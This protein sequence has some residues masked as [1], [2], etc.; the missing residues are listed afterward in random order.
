MSAISNEA[1]DTRGADYADVSS[2]DVSLVFLRF[3]LRGI[4]S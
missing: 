3:D 1:R 4:D 2:L